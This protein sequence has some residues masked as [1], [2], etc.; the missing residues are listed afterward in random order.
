MKLHFREAK[1]SDL[2]NLIQL[3]ANDPLGKT[4]EDITTP[5]KL[6]YIQAF[7][8]IETDPNNRIIIAEIDNQLVGMAQLT[9]IPNLTYQ[10]SWR[11]LI[12]GVRVDEKYRGQGYGEEIFT[13]LI[14]LAKEKGCS[15]VQL[16]SDKQ[17]PEA[18]RF[19]EKLGFIPSHVGF[20]LTIKK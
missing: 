14:S 5:V 9:F 16:T 13:Y 15:L 4:R 20:K 17:R 10:G 1:M 6:S 18:L 11:C 19:Y 8:E 3:L 12:E 7:S 2:Q